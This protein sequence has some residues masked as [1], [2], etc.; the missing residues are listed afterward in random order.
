MRVIVVIADGFFDSSN[1]DAQLL[2]YSVFRDITLRQVPNS[3]AGLER[4]T[5]WF[6]YASDESSGESFAQ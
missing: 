5:R 6:L 3:T 2:R 4:E 1:R